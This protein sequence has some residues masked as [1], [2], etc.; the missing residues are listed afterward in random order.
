M[1]ETTQ[2]SPQLQELNTLSL[3]ANQLCKSEALPACYKNAA[4]VLVALQ[5]GK[6]M[7]LQPMQSLNSLYIVNGKI[8][9]WGSSQVQLL[10]QHGWKIQI[11]EHTDKVCTVA[12]NKGDES[13]EYSA[14]FAELPAG[15]KA[16]AFAP[17]EKLYYH[18]I[19]RLIRFYVPEVLGG[20][21][22]LYN[23]DEV[24]VIDE[25]RKPA[26]DQVDTSK[27]TVDMSALKPQTPEAEE[28]KPAIP[29]IDVTA[30]KEVAKSPKPTEAQM[31]RLFKLI[32][33]KV[34][35][36]DKRTEFVDRAVEKYSLDSIRDI[37]IGQYDELCN[38]LLGL[39]I[40]Q[41]QS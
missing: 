35:D 16:K 3:V 24:E 18:V 23:E 27:I 14:T 20:M 17:K 4:N 6:E 30:V 32:N 7:G 15:S 25:K 34:A 12:I 1:S 22:N 21:S 33:D 36:E 13:F 5:T 41:K 10:K 38:Y 40:N 2:L 31:Q 37:T 8:Q 9:I 29:T 39:D 19:S 28:S 26:A 11:K